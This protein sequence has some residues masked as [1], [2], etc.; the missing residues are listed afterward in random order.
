MNSKLAIYSGALLLFFLQADQTCAA[1]FNLQ[2][3]EVGRV[4][5]YSTGASDQVVISI[6]SR[7]LEVPSGTRLWITFADKTEVVPVNSWGGKAAADGVATVRMEVDGVK[8]YDY[9][10][11]AVKKKEGRIRV[12]QVSFRIPG[13]AVRLCDGIHHHNFIP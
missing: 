5:V 13:R 1:P 6:S 3:C 7:P 10:L 8:L 12:Q 4:D 11:L 2:G 9:G